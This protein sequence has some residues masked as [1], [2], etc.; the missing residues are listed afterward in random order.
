MHLFCNRVRIGHSRSSKVI[1]F[2]PNR[3]GAMVHATSYLSLI[4]TFVLSCTVP[5]I[6]DLLAENC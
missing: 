1:D 5:E 3:K 4:V 6:G 2:G